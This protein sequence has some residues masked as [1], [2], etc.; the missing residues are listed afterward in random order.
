MRVLRPNQHYSIYSLVWFSKNK[1]RN[2]VNP[3]KETVS[4]LVLKRIYNDLISLFG[5]EAK[6][7]KSTTREGEVVAC[8]QLFC[9]IARVEHSIR[10]EK[11]AKFIGGKDH[12][13]II[14]HVNKAKD[15]IETGDEYFGKYY[16]AYK[17]RKP[18]VETEGLTKT[19]LLL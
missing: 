12:T 14:H 7:I 2:F 8:R 4:D 17:E 1:Y 15:F 9:Y 5:Y 11:I 13:S 10:F 3:D 16:R 18:S 6:Q 19:K